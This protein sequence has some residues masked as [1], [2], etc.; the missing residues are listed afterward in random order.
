MLFR[1]I[2]CRE[3]Y[4]YYHATTDSVSVSTYFMVE[5]LP[6]SVAAALMTVFLLVTS[7][8]LIF[9]KLRP[10]SEIFRPPSNFVK[11]GQEI[12]I[13][14]KETQF[15]DQL[16]AR[17]F[18]LTDLTFTVILCAYIPAILFT[19]STDL[20]VL[21]RCGYNLVCGPTTILTTRPQ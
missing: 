14:V 10:P 12:F 4:V 8:S 20:N 13:P 3:I 15:P 11:L 5:R 2:S 6:L 16:S 19:Q 1:S 17:I 21:F 7:A 18:R 9:H